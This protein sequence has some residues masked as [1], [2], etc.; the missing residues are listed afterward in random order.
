METTT[1]APT[2]GASAAA[3]TPAPAP[4]AAANPFFVESPLPFGAPQ[5][6][7]I[8]PSHFREALERGM[9]EQRAEVSRIAANAEPATFENTI[10]P[11]ERAGALLARTQA[12]F[13]NMASANTNDEIQALQREFAP[14]LAAHGAAI[15]LDPALFARIEAIHARRAQLGFTPE[16]LRLVE[17]YHTS[18]VRQGAKLE[19]PARVRYAEINERLAVLSTKFSQNVLA[20]T[21]QW[22]MVLDSEADLAGLSPALIAAA[23]QTAKAAGQDGKWMITLQRSSVEPFLQFSTRRDLREKAFKAWAARGDNRDAE[24]NTAIIAEMVRLRNEA[25]KLLGHDT[26][27]EFQLDDRMAKTPEAAR[28]LLERV[29]RPALKRALQERADM[30]KLIDAEG[31]GFKLEAWDWR[32]YA[33]KVRQQRYDLSAAELRPYFSLDQMI[34]AQFYTAERL[35]GLQFAE[36]KDLPVYHPDVRVWEV[37]D[38]DGRHVGL[39]YGDYIAR[40]NKQSGAWMSSYRRQ[41]GLDGP[42][43]PIVVNVMSVSKGAPTLVSYDDAETMFHEFGHALHG[44]LSNVKYPTLSGTAVA[45]DFVEFPAQIYEHWLLTPEILGR[46]A[47]H[48]ETGAPI[49]Q[50]LVDRLIASRTFNQ[51]FATVEFVSSAFVDLDF[52][53]LKDVPA[54]LDATAFEKATRA[55][56]GMPDEIVMRHRPPHFSH[57]FAGGYAAGYYSYMWSEI[58][59]ADGFD[60][61]KETGDVFNPEVAKKLY[62][63]VYSAGNSRDGMAAYV[64][65]RGREPSVEPLLRNRGFL[66]EPKPAKKKAPRAG[67]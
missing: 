60:A 32:F 7:K 48:H 8:Q 46:F 25:A 18:F 42:V 57:T 29:W 58:L 64:G 12:V 19:G 66:E 56:I 51:G 41:S 10:L 49:P 55:R 53:S 14:K 28:D 21:R 4:A 5:F 6:D 24:D 37:K 11:L 1:P 36:R 40:P 3:A 34:A 38:K 16:Q 17:R 54:N 45:T 15:A 35:F 30:Q 59:D 9:A 43:T 27:A 23:A 39:F 22:T 13:G 65:F 31:G 62:Q 26:F 52:H 47:R 33:E 67:S 61:F 44:L 20:D 63:Y 2:A 50:A